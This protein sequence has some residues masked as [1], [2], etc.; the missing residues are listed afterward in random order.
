MRKSLIMGTKED[1]LSSTRLRNKNEQSNR[2]TK[3]A[4]TMAVHNTGNIVS[5]DGISK[6][7]IVTFNHPC[8]GN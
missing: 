3:Q 4:N 7:T 1:V 2:Y 8:V 5:P 6:R